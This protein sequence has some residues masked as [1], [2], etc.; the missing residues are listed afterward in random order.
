[1]QEQN[2]ALIK[3]FWTEEHDQFLRDNYRSMSARAIGE[4]IGKTKMSVIGRA[5]RLKLN[6]TRKEVLAEQ[7]A[8]RRVGQ[9]STYV[10]KKSHK[11]RRDNANR[12]GIFRGPRQVP[13]SDKVVTVNITPLGGVGVKLWEATSQ[14]CRWVVGEPK[15]LTFCGNH[16]A[17]GSSYCPGHHEMTKRRQ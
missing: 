14:H 13:Y 7:L 10:K 17:E 1:M 8:N 9:A 2:G 16:K 3:A 15:D 12:A 6:R 11:E 5:N 4:I